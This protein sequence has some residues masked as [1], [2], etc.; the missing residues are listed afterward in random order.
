MG[1]FKDYTMERLARVKKKPTYPSLNEPVLLFNKFRI[2]EVVGALWVIVFFGVIRSNW[3][4]SLILVMFMLVGSPA[5]RKRTPP[6]FV[7]R[8]I[9]DYFSKLPLGSFTWGRSHSSF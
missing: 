6:S 2:Y 3:L 1:D 4:V 7:Y 5:L 8:K 9:L